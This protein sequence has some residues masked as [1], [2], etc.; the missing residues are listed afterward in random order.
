MSRLMKSSVFLLFIFAG[1]M[2]C[3]NEEKVTSDS[4]E[5]SKSDSKEVAKNEEEQT[6]E[7]AEEPIEYLY[8]KM[9]FDKREGT[10]YSDEQGS[11]SLI[12]QT[13]YNES[14]LFALK[15]EGSLA[16]E[17]EKSDEGGLEELSLNAV[18]DDGT[19]YEGDL[20]TTA[21]IVT[22]YKDKEGNTLLFFTFGDIIPN[23]KLARL[24]YKLGDQEEYKTLEFAGQK[25]QLNY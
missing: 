5:S 14:S 6:E 17:W 11:I 25:E 1:L 22:H 21:Q 7:P 2:G 24:D 13:P 18:Y 3:S 16:D 20:D 19:S 9:E 4:K 8:P 12:G 10:L 15:Y 23:G